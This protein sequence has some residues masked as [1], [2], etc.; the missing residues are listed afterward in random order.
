MARRGGRSNFV[1][2]YLFKVKPQGQVWHR[3]WP[4]QQVSSSWHWQLQYWTSS[5]LKMHQ[6]PSWQCGSVCKVKLVFTYLIWLSHLFAVYCL[7]DVLSLLWRSV[8]ADIRSPVYTGVMRGL[9][10][11]SCMLERT[12]LLLTCLISIPLM[13]LLTLVP[14]RAYQA[15]FHSY[16]DNINW[17][18]LMLAWW[19]RSSMAVGRSLQHSILI[20]L[21]I[22]F[23]ISS[24]QS[25]NCTDEAPWSNL[26]SEKQLSI[27]KSQ[28][29]NEWSPFCDT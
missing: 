4:C 24:Q 19:H 23:Q 5:G 8:S 27:Y 7:V 17:L 15:L 21:C 9:Y 22:F 26:L 18:T 14:C 10:A 2:C 13:P 29:T 3:L 28:E 1:C 25:S 20:L 11:G 12:K 16:V 6:L